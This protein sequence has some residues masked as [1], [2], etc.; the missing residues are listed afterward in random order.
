[1]TKNLYR[2]DKVMITSGEFWRC[3]HGYTKFSNAL[4]VR[5][6]L[7]APVA[8]YECKIARPKAMEP[9]AWFE[10]SRSG[11]AT[12]RPKVNVGLHSRRGMIGVYTHDD[13]V[14]GNAWIEMHA[15]SLS[16]IAGLPLYDA[17]PDQTTKEF[18][19]ERNASVA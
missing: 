5:C 10:I 18:Y 14:Q 9:Q 7:A 17:R 15:K 19:Q 11:Q 6:A 2:S 1:M 3:K 4:C 13:D 8:F 16:H 12:D